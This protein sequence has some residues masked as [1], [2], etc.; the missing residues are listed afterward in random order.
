MEK[1]PKIVET[2]SMFSSIAVSLAAIIGLLSTVFKP[3]RNGVLWIIRRIYGTRK[4]EMMDE[5]IGVR[6]ELCAKIEGVKD[7]INDVSQKVDENEMDRIRSEIFKYGN[8]AR[9]GEKISGEEFRRLQEVFDKYEHLG[10]NGIAHDEFRFIT[11]YYN[12]SGWLKFVK[13]NGEK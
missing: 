12:T 11:N 2:L 3:V 5:I 13:A 1:M 9:K 7:S 4:D 8:Y 10:G 6:D